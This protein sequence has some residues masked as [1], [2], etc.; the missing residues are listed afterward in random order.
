MIVLTRFHL[1]SKIAVLE[2]HAFA[3]FFFFP[4]RFK[5]E[6][7]T[8]KL[9]STSK[10]RDRR[11]NDQLVPARLILNDNLRIREKSLVYGVFFFKKKPSQREARPTN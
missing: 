2:P 8:A 4:T 3:D 9:C 6:G 5:I 7:K 10:D 1:L 11:T